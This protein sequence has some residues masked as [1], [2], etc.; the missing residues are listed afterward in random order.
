MAPP[1]GLEDPG[2]EKG[3]AL[4]AFPRNLPEFTA[5]AYNCAPS[6]TFRIWSRA[7]PTET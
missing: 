1:R 2:E 3:K 7:G 4:Q 5:R 6:S